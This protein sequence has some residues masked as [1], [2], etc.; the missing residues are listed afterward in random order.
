VENKSQ[1]KN[2]KRTKSCL[3][4]PKKNELEM[5]KNELRLKTVLIYLLKILIHYL[6][7]F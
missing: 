1:L 6:D 5:A 2:N 4:E 7:T 3:V